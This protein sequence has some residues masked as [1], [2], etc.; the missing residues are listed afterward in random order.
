MKTY[1][2][3]HKIY[4][5]TEVEAESVE[6]LKAKL[7]TLNLDTTVTEQN[8]TELYS[9]CEVDGHYLI[10]ADAETGDLIEENT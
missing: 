10:I 3:E 9:M 1:K 6:A 7:L 4:I 5:E 8:G 2:V